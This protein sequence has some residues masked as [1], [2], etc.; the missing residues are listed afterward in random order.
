MESIVWLKVI[1]IQDPFEHI[2]II[3]LTDAAK[4]EFQSSIEIPFKPKEQFCL[5]L[6]FIEASSIFTINAFL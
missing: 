1:F 2:A 5:V 3:M 6:L 4:V